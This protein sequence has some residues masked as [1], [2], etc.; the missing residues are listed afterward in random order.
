MNGDVGEIHAVTIAEMAATAV[1]GAITSTV[2]RVRSGSRTNRFTGGEA[3]PPDPSDPKSVWRRWA[4]S[5][6]IPAVEEVSAAIAVHLDAF[7]RPDAVVLTYLP[8]PGEVDPGPP[9]RDRTL[10]VTRTPRRGPLSVHGI[11]QP[12]ERHPFGYEQPV[13]GAE[14]FVGPIDVVLVPG[15]VFGLDGSRLGRG[16][17]HYD[18]LLAAHDVPV[19]IGVA[20]DLHVVAAVPTEAHDIPMTHLVSES[21]VR[22]TR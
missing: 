20:A 1:A 8:M 9:A 14:V 18:R 2:T 5:V 13:E 15:L 6:T 21:G 11:D 19:R 16:A 10:L 4:G 12:R 17:G 7:L 3:S 22:P